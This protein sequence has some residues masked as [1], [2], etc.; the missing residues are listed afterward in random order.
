MLRKAVQ[1]VKLCAILTATKT[2]RL[3]LNVTCS[4]DFGYIIIIRLLNKLLTQT[5]KNV[6]EPL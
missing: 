6:S 4:L 1:L 5:Q 2:L 3:I